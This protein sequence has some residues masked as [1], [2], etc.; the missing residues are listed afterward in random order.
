MLHSILEQLEREVL[1]PLCRKF[2]LRQPQC[3]GEHHCAAKKAGVTIKDP[4]IDTKRD[5]S[6]TDDGGCSK[7]SGSQSPSKRKSATGSKGSTDLHNISHLD[8]VSS[9]A[10]MCV[11][12]LLLC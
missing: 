8:I 10:P 7:M 2:E 4:L 5:T 1:K 3:F 6:S 9:V 11:S 12:A